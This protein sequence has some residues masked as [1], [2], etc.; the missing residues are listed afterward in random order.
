MMYY[1]YDSQ[2]DFY[3][4]PF[5]A[6]EI[7]KEVT[8]RIKEKKGINTRK[9]LVIIMN[10]NTNYYSMV[11]ES[12]ENEYDI[13]KV[14]YKTPDEPCIIFYYFNI[15][16]NDHSI[17]IGNS[18][19]KLGGNGIT[20]YDKPVPFQITVTEKN[21]KVPSWYKEGI[22]YQIFVDRFRKSGD[23]DLYEG[24][25]GF[26]KYTNWYENNKYIKTSKGDIALWD[27]FGGNIRGIIEK[28]PYLKSL[29][30]SIIYLNPI[31][32]ANSN[33][34]YD[35]A[36][37]EKLDPSFGDDK[38]F[39]EFITVC[40]E[41][42]INIILDGVFSHVGSNSKYFNKHEQYN[43][44]GAYQSSESP[45]YSWFRF[46]NKLK[47]GYECWWGNG[48]LPNV[49][50]MEPSYLDYILRSDNSIIKQ[51]MKK[52]VKGW[53]LDVADELPD[54]FIKILKETAK[55]MDEES[56]VI[57]EVWEDASNKVSYGELRKYFLGNELDAVMNYPFRGTFIDYILNHIDADRV[58]KIMMSLY[59][60]Y[61]KEYFYA[62]MNHVGT[63]DTERILTILGEDWESEIEED[64]RHCH[65]MSDEKMKLAVKRIKL[66]A[67]IQAIFPGVPCIY[68]GDEAGVEGLRDPYCR[69]TYP[70]GRENEEVLNWYTKLFNIRDKSQILKKGDWK[71]YYCKGS[72]F[73]ITR[74][75]ENEQLL[76]IVNSS[77][78]RQ[79]VNNAFG[80]LYDIINDEYVEGN[81][82]MD[83]LSCRLLKVQ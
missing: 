75:Y 59:E 82:V 56:V 43:T 83:S 37:Y 14:V 42:G 62:C 70:W 28:I 29:G 65:R 10:N 39:N 21:I 2:D 52:G 4:Q 16:F 67:F 44:L 54:E 41:N 61:P 78:D 25:K 33:H 32:E 22:M 47:T 19:D 23:K 66:I 68:Y 27:V 74:A 45:Y 8:F 53:R 13:Y 80:K 76:C 15:H 17:Y 50:E 9:E 77:F 57:G 81:I 30:V 79:E 7:G 11:Y 12:E 1:I 36:D 3:K 35:T 49:E 38:D 63:H 51:W 72:I 60:N 24:R 31:F 55:Q 26:V 5:G 18:I 40:K 64:E 73:S 58:K 48:S 71:P 20:Y 6:V 34:K 69:K 46:N